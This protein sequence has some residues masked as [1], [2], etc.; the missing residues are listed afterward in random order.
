MHS[1]VLPVLV[2]KRITNMHTCQRHQ[3]CSPSGS[4]LPHLHNLSAPAVCV[5]LLLALPLPSPCTAQWVF[6]YSIVGAVW[7]Q[8]Q[9][10]FAGF[11]TSAVYSPD[12]AEH[13]MALLQHPRLAQQLAPG[14]PSGLCYDSVAPPYFA[15]GFL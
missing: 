8:S 7:I 15:C 2:L 6:T 9:W 3:P 10:D 5:L 13:F 11:P 4:N 14:P 1:L 12:V